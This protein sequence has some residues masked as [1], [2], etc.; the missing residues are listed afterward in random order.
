MFVLACI[1]MTIQFIGRHY[2]TRETDIGYRKMKETKAMSLREGMSDYASVMK[3]MLGN[4]PPL[5]IFGVYIL[6]NFQMT[7]KTT[8]VSIFM[9]EYLHLGAGLISVFP[10]FSSVIMLIFMRWIMP[11]I[12]EQDVHRTMVWGSLY[13]YCP[14]SYWC[15]RR[16]GSAGA[17]LEHRHCR[18][19]H[20]DD[21]P[22]LGDCGGQRHRR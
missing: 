4:P 11:R 17:E 21:V 20:H 12:G 16:K 19:R 8:Y 6:F 13:R 15:L 5:M 1:L 14:M 3:S 2:A 10:A 7:V 22:I 9:V 18:N